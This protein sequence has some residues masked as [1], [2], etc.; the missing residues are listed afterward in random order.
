MAAQV[1]GVHE[2]VERLRSEWNSRTGQDPFEVSAAALCLWTYLAG[3]KNKGSVSLKSL[4]TLMLCY[5]PTSLTSSCHLSPHQELDRVH[6]E[7]EERKRKTTRLVVRS[8]QELPQQQQ[9]LNFLQVGNAPSSTPASFAQLPS[10]TVAAPPPF[11]ST[12]VA[13]AFT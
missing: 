9:S 1:A 13:P 7:N 6:A 3:L 5:P 8:G 12:F 2:M 4:P 11:A 10:S